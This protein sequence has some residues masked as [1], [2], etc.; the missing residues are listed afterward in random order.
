MQTINNFYLNATHMLIEPGPVVLVTTNYRGK[1]NIMTLSSLIMLQQN[2]PFLLG[3]VLGPWNFS[4]KALYKTGE[5]VISIPTVDMASTV[6]E[7]GN[8]SGEEIDKFKTFNLTPL[9]AREVR[10]PL[11]AESLANIEC[12]VIDRSMV[13]KYSLFILKAVNVWTDNDR[14]E[15][16]TLHHNG[17]GTFVLDGE[18][19]N[20]K[21]KM[22]KWPEYL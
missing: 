2:P 12:Q 7:I 15:R 6:V 18:I 17:D 3:F 4:Y 8:C 11:I 16:R 21:E 20:L 9:P 19:I 5:C 10:A 22:E 13:G 1:S 14:K